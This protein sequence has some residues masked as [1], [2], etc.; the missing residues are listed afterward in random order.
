MPL[1]SNRY[2]AQTYEPARLKRPPGRNISDARVVPNPYNIN[3]DQNLLFSNR[4][5]LAFFNIPGQC[6]IKIFTEMGELIRELPHLDG[7]GDHFWDI[8]TESLQ[9]VSTGIY[10]AVI[11]DLETGDKVIR[12]FTIIR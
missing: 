3:T 1:K 2:Y 10:F 6:T 11:E 5:A 8:Q 4:D 7:S 9:L 12:K